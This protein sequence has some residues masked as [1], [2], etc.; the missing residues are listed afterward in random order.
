ME[1]KTMKK[2]SLVAAIAML[3]V[4]AI[5]LT[6]STYAWFSTSSSAAVGSISAT[7]TNNTGNLKV[8]AAGTSAKNTVPKTALTDA[9]YYLSRDITEQ[10]PLPTGKTQVYQTLTPVSL[11]MSATETNGVTTYAPVFKILQ[12]DGTYYTSCNNA[13][14]SEYTSYSFDIIYENGTTVDD[15]IR[16]TPTFTA[17]STT[18]PF[19]YGLIAITVDGSTT[20]YITDNTGYTPVTAITAGYPDPD[21]A[22][23]YLSQV[24]DTGTYNDIL[25]SNDTGTWTAGSLTGTT[26]IPQTGIEIDGTHGT[27]TTA[28][29][30]VYVWAEGQDA[31]CTGIV[32]GQSTYFAFSLAVDPHTP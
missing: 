6:S 23:E 24:K 28:N 11:S 13:A 26:V 16:L 3:V 1:E 7:I 15:V 8:R 21:H 12:Y 25:D 5:V 9:D 18:N 10:N 27:T 22:G 29:V 31:Q 14:G 32:D 17:N 4:S 2:R 30:T 20:Y 19:T